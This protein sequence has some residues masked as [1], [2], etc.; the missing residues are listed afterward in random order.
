MPKKI[1]IILICFLLI[2]LA[3]CARS[4]K[5]PYSNIRNIDSA[6]GENVI[7]FGDSLTSGMGAERGEDYPSILRQKLGV[8]VINAGR[9]GDTTET[10]LSRL[11]KVLEKNPKIVIVELG[12]NDFLTSFQGGWV[13][14]DKSHLKAFENLKI[15]VNKIQNVGVVVIVAGVKLNSRYDKGYRKLAKETGSVLVPDIMEG[16]YNN[17]NLMSPDNRH[18]NALGYQ[19]MADKFILVLEPLL[20]EMEK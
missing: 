11:D 18:P 9:S 3:G 16:I 1:F 10:A 4:P 20:V 13:E 15:I 19:K 2:S 17:Q 12:A 5:D 8:P 14:A 6:I 7:C